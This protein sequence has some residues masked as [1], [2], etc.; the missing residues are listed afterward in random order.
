MAKKDSGR[1]V[2]LVGAGSLAHALA[3]LLPKAGYRISEFVVRSKSERRRE[4]EKLAQASRARLATFETASWDAGIIWVA[5]SDGAIASTAE[6]MAPL[7][8]WRGKIVLHSSGALASAELRALKRR[9]AVVGSV[10][11]MMTFVPGKVPVVN[12][13]AWT[14]EGDRQAASVAR[15]VVRALKGVPL[16]IEARDKSRYHVFAAF[17]SPLM[18]V[19]LETAARLA[20][21]A[22]IPARE[23][24]AVMRPIVEQTIQ[25]YFEKKGSGGGA[26]KAFSGPLIRGDVATIEGHLRALRGDREA[27]SLYRALIAAALKSD[28]PVRN[29]AAIRRAIGE[30]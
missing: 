16:S 12:A 24:T 9:G 20:V 21:A 14:I 2:V 22:G 3:S 8:D 1:S 11:P 4:A 23:L 29:K 27:L 6:L 17:L 18:L 28:L 15:R 25:N 26:G 19:H 5:V 10:H 30:K 7:A 13:V